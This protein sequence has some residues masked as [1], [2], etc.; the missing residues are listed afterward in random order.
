MFCLLIL[1]TICEISYNF[2]FK[3]TYKVLSSQLFKGFIKQQI[4]INYKKYQFNFVNILSISSL[5]SLRFCITDN[6]SP[7]IKDITLSQFIDCKII[8]SIKRLL[9]GKSNS[10]SILVQLEP[11]NFITKQQ[12]FLQQS[13]NIL[14]CRL[15]IDEHIQNIGEDYEKRLY[16]KGK[17][18]TIKC[19]NKIN[20]FKTIRILFLVD[21]KY[22][23]QYPQRQA[24]EILQK[25][26]ENLYVQVQADDKISQYDKFQRIGLANTINK[27][28]DDNWG[29]DNGDQEQTERVRIRKKIL[30][31]KVQATWNDKLR[32]W[33]KINFKIFR[34]YFIYL[35][36]YFYRL[37]KYIENRKQM[38]LN[39]KGEQPI[40]C[41]QN[42][43][44]MLQKNSSKVIFQFSSNKDNLK[45][46]DK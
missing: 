18:K 25:E 34:D 44:E 42:F 43:L 30:K 5:K 45:I 31:K 19:L 36:Q 33:I 11:K 16:L 46:S 6:P 12:Q 35:A 2:K 14:I 1:S 21:E 9:F 41:L 17:S 13:T 15:L 26:N 29:P 4:A 39:Q 8:F 20:N 40:K 10:Y 27:Q 24:V 3:Q 7:I 22:A 38:A 23:I 37:R 28:I 32:Q